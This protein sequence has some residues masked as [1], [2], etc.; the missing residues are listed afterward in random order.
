VRGDLRVL[1]RAEPA[2]AGGRGGFDPGPNRLDHED[3]G[4]PRDDRLA[5]GAELAR[6][7]CHQPQRA[8]HPGRAVGVGCLDEDRRREDP[9]QVEGTGMVEPHGAADHRRRRAAGHA[10]A[11]DLVAVARALEVELEDVR[12]GD[13]GLA[14]QPVPV[15]VRHEREIAGLQPQRV[16]AVDL[17][18]PASG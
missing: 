7:D 8:L 4:E 14:A 16:G 2:G 6:L 1:E 10:V 3:V 11:Q 17:E 5:A 9:D 13:V 12:D 18:Q 15:A